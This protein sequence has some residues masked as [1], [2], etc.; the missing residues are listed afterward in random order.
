M[1]AMA[2]IRLRLGVSE[3]VSIQIEP[4]AHVLVYRSDAD[5]TMWLSER[6]PQKIRF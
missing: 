5:G 3:L 1:P 2:G 4:G 6:I